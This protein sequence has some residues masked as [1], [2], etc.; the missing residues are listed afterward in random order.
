MEKVPIFTSQVLKHVSQDKLY[1]WS[2]N[3]GQIWKLT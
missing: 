1:S 2:I 3:H